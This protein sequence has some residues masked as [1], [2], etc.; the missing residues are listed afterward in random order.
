MYKMP[1][2][3]ADD[4]MSV[5]DL[6]LIGRTDFMKQVDLGWRKGEKTLI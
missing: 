1:G 5:N 3:N 4:I 2:D 6:V